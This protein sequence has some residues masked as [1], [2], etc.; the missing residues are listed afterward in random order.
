MK[1]RGNQG[2]PVPAG[3]VRGYADG[4]PNR[5]NSATSQETRVAWLLPSADAA[6]KR[7]CDTTHGLGPPLNLPQGRESTPAWGSQIR[8]FW[9]PS[10]VHCVALARPGPFLGLSGPDGP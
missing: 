8:S 9:A 3:E 1:G 10:H 2:L 5:A 7:A 6:L 4:N